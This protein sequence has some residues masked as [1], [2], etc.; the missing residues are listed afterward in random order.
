MSTDTKEMEKKGKNK[1][2]YKK[3]EKSGMKKKE[4]KE[5]HTK[6]R[7]IKMEK[8][9]YTEKSWIEKIKGNNKKEKCGIKTF[10]K[11]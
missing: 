9:K 5:K 11:I 7:K 3:K 4:K 10:L 1:Q 6:I 8:R 2:A